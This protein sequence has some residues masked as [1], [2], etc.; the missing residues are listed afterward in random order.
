MTGR[1]RRGGAFDHANRQYVGACLGAPIL[2]RGRRDTRNTGLTTR[3][4]AL[5]RGAVTAYSHVIRANSPLRGE[6]R[7][8]RAARIQ[9]QNA[10][11]PSW[12]SPVR[13]RSAA[14]FDE[15]LRL[16]PWPLSRLCAQIVPMALYNPS[17]SSRRVAALPSR[18]VRFGMKRW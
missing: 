4:A 5:A 14:P 9:W 8:R 17:C 18:R 1:G 6:Y 11:F 16:T 7:G 13:I 10:S 15:G 3:R 2:S 12:T